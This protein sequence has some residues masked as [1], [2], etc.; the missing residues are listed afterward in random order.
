ME[1]ETRINP[2]ILSYEPPDVCLIDEL[3]LGDIRTD[4]HF[5]AKRGVFGVTLI[6]FMNKRPLEQN[7]FEWLIHHWRE[8]IILYQQNLG[9]YLS[10]F[11]FHKVKQ[12]I[13]EKQFYIAEKLSKITSEITGKLLS[14]PISFAVIIAIV[15]SDILY[16]KLILVIGLLLAALVVAG[17]VKNQQKQ[18]ERIR[19]SKQVTFNSF[20][21]NKDL[22]PVDNQI[23]IK[24][25]VAG[26]DR[27]ETYLFR[28]LWFFRVLSWVPVTVSALIVYCVYA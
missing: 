23:D 5:S 20:E 11:A 1:I 15:K 6:E 28:L 3:C 10:G 13:A 8:F 2:T 24:K 21:G 22:Y 19:H 9:T 26:L 4:P 17:S 7:K 16:E 27:N 12:E 14:I 25:M 18:L